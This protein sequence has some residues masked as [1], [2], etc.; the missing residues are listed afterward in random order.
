MRT[1][2]TAVASLKLPAPRYLLPIAILAFIAT[3]HRNST[4]HRLK[5]VL[6]TPP[7]AQASAC[8]PL[9][10]AFAFSPLFFCLCADGPGFNLKFRVG[11]SRPA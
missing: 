6:P 9:P 3:Q 7:V 4:P 5:P 1:W 8:A 11:R 10:F 2:R